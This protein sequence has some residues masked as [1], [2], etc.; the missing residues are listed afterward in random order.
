MRA[1]IIDVAI[2]SVP[3]HLV[4]PKYELNISAHM[5]EYGVNCVETPECDLGLITAVMLF[6]P[7]DRFATVTRHY[8]S[9]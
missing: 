8:A 2:S 3:Y 4:Q 5:Y 9:L 7:A 6:Y 1:N